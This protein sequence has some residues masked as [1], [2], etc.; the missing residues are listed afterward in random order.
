VCIAEVWMPQL[1]PT[2]AYIAK[3]GEGDDTEALSKSVTGVARG[4]VSGAPSL[5]TRNAFSG[6]EVP[7]LTGND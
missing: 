7:A 3:S 1:T 2:S 4:W 6:V 5:N